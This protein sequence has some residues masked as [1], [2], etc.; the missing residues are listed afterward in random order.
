MENTKIKIN[1]IELTISRL[2]LK[3][4]T[5]LD[6]IRKD[7][8]DAVSTM[9]FDKYFIAI[10]QFIETASFP[11]LEWSQVPWYQVLEVY[12][13]VV[14]FNQPTIDFPILH[15]HE[16]TD[17]KLPWEYGGRAWYFWLN[18]FSKNYGWTENQIEYLDLD[19]A[20]GL[21]Q[22]ISIDEQLEK[23]WEWGLSEIAYSYNSS[24]KKSEYRPLDRPTWMKPLIPKQ[25]PVVRI[26]K[27]HLPIGNVVDLSE[28]K[29]NK[30]GI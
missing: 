19:T 25:L 17:K 11:V 10:V 12:G 13:K 24:T 1:D 27:Q 20:L 23:E 5:Q 4:W 15:G 30:S 21:Y 6:G 14:E 29:K 7:M 18:L 9:D 22:E 16:Q 8:E 2:N 28:P 26:M 3:G